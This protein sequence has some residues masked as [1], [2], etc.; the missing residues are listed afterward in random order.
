M[1]IG[2]PEIAQL[3]MIGSDAIIGW[4]STAGS[5]IGAYHLQDKDTSQ[6]VPNTK[7][8]VTAGTTLPRYFIKL[9]CDRFRPGSERR[10]NHQIHKSF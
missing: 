5:E 9:T 3:K 7:L 8:N 2:F 6:I 4:S 1:A 10:H